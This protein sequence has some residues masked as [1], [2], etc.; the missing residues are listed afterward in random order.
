MISVHQ[1]NMF[2]ARV[3]M[4]AIPSTDITSVLFQSLG[5]DYYCYSLQNNATGMLLKIFLFS[6][7]I[8]I[9]KKRKKKAKENRAHVS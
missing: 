7:K 4:S 6:Q 2:K 1:K 3:V 9:Q 8:R 5:V